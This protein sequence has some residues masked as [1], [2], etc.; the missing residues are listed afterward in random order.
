[1]KNND[2]LSLGLL[3]IAL[4][5]GCGNNSKIEGTYMSPVDQET[6]TF[7]PDGTVTSKTS[8]G[9]VK[10][11]KPYSV[12]GDRYIVTPVLTFTR[13]PDGSVDGGMMFGDLV[14]K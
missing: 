13:H 3:L 2:L 7:N 11:T 1:M 12:D 10:W 14:K 4:L 8:D 6:F 5:G 9:V